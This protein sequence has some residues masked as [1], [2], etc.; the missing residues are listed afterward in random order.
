MDKRRCQ[1]CGGEFTPNRRWAKYCS[2]RCHMQW[3]AKEQRRMRQ[4]CREH[5]Q[6]QG[7]EE[8]RTDAA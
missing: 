5:G 7:H 6:E 3:H 2:P 1:N 4:W 8:A